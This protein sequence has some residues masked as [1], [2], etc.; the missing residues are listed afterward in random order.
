MK[1]MGRLLDI[2]SSWKLSIALMILGALFYSLLTIW[3]TSSPPHVVGLIGGMLPFKLLYAILLANTALCLWRRLPALASGISRSP[4]L[5]KGPARWQAQLTAEGKKEVFDMMGRMGYRAR[6]EGEGLWGVRNRWTAMGTFLFHGAFFL[7]AAGFL[8]T[9]IWRSEVKTWV[10]VGERFEGRPDQFLP[11]ER[12]GN[13]GK[14]EIA[15][16]DFEVLEIE[17]AFWKDILL[18]TQLKARLAFPGGNERITRINRPLMAGWDTFM[19]LSGFGYAPAYT[20]YGPDGRPVDAAVARLNLFPPGQRD[21]LTLAGLPH[22]VYLI[23]IPDAA[24]TSGGPVM[25]GLDLA[26][27]RIAVRIYR[28]RL[29]LGSAL[30]KPGEAI[31]FEGYT[32]RFD[33]IRYWGEFTTVRDP[34]AL[35]ILAGFAIGLIG[36]SLKLRGRRGEVAWEPAPGGG[37][38]LRGWGG[39][40]S[41]EAENGGG[42]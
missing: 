25:R 38:F 40:R 20:L 1:Y 21:T 11:S 6:E 37:G 29:D 12:G 24:V 30:L 27:P 34:G 18:F 16:P 39:A 42:P 28:G 41:P 23:V 3:A 7:V 32:L 13:A 5:T 8:A 35:V 9:S 14:P 33:E 10:A 31:T 36:L 19:R 15:L 17:P 2:L 22:R 4:Q 26:D